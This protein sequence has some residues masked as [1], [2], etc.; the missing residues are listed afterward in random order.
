M[1]KMAAPSTPG[2]QAIPGPNDP[3]ARKRAKREAAQKVLAELASAASEN[4]ASRK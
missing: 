3:E 1:P 2:V 4:D